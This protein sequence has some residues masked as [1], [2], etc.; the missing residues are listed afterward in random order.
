MRVSR[1]A[2]AINQGAI[3]A[4]DPQDGDVFVAWRRF[5]S[6]DAPDADAV[7]LAR[8]PVGAG[9]FS[10]PGR[11]RGFA[12][13]GSPSAA[14]EKI[15]E[16]RKKRAQPTVVAA[17]S[18]PDQG[19]SPYQLPDQRVSG[20]GD[21]R[22]QQG[23]HRVGRA[24]IRRERPS[25][26]DG[27]ARILVATTTD[28]VS[29]TTPVI[30]A[31]ETL[32]HQVMPSLAFA[33]GK[34]MLV[35]YDLRETAAQ[36]FGK[37]SITDQ[38]ASRQRQASDHR[39]PRVARHD[40][41]ARRHSRRRSR[42]PTTSLG[43]RSGTAVLEQLQINPPNLPMF[44]LGTVP[45]IGDYI[46]VS[47]A[48]AFVPAAGGQWVYNT[49]ASATF[50]VFHATWTDNRDVRAPLDGNWANYTPPTIVGSD[51][52]ACSIRR[53]RSPS[54][55]PATPAHATRTSTPLAS[56][57]ACWSARRAT[58]SSSRPRCSA[59]SWCSRRTRPRRRRRFA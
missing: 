6:P 41:P 42:C 31:N 26:V 5:A 25:P 17:V 59:A 37:I 1:T 39:H 38:P 55:M 9:A 46:D 13:T 23:L 49:A 14:L 4:I 40:R 34:L 35:Y 48:P 43:F 18:N 28:A 15:F 58:P 19:T 7:M 53:S 51:G 50:P 32:G 22:Q 36:V 29:F 10:P 57:A 56:A 11:A 3:I 2:D 16:H 8:L 45:F 21:R 27:D 54:A 33:G 30:A 47:P 24:R 12:G 52:R 20:D 44:K